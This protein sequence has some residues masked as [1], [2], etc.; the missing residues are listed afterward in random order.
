MS[1]YNF[2]FLNKR[3]RN[4]QHL[5][6][7]EIELD[8]D[9]LDR[10]SDFIIDDIDLEI[11]PYDIESEKDQIN[12]IIDKRNI[13]WLC[14]FTPRENL[15]GIKKEGLK[16]KN[17]LDSNAVRTDPGRCDRYS[18]AICLSISKPNVWMLQKKIEQGF[19]LCLLLIDPAVLYEKKCVFYPHNAA[20]ASCRS[21]DVSE[22][23]G[24]ASLESLFDD[25]ISFQK[26]GQEPQAIWR[27]RN[28]NKK[29]Q[30]S[31]TTSDQAEVQCLENIEP[32]YIQHIIEGDILLTYDELL[33]LVDEQ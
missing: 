28:K 14:H 32:K 29:L 22:I 12:T 11:L 21:M 8:P 26:S 20:T 13:R 33:D 1:T 16:I 31:E 5:E 27:N 9:Q 10:K 7:I 23:T 4:E 2:T 24:A 15:D 25:P 17:H 30:K 19:D 6:D 3:Y 18:N